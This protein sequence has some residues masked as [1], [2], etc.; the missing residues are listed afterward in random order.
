MATS[1][2]GKIGAVLRRFQVLVEHDASEDVWVTSVPGLNWLSTYGES[3]EEALEQTREAILGYFEAATKEGIPLPP[4]DV[5][6]EVVD[7]EVATP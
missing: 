1:K 6:A 7:L 5:E 2:V 3:R 4:G